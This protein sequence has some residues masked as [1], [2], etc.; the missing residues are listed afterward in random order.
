VG[1][2]EDRPPPPALCFADG[3]DRRAT[4]NQRNDIRSFRLASPP[5]P[6]I[7][8][9]FS[10]LESPIETVAFHLQSITKELYTKIDDVQMQRLR[11]LGNMAVDFPLPPMSFLSYT[12]SKM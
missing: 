2:L 1:K 7:S 5:K 9:A 3:T 4:D 10:F 11:F 6:L 12:C 8:V